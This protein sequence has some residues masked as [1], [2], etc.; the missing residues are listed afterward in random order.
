ME[1]WPRPSPPPPTEG[2]ITDAAFPPYPRRALPPEQLPGLT[3]LGLG[4]EGAPVPL[5][6]LLS[7]ALPGLVTE[8]HHVPDPLPRGVEVVALGPGER[9]FALLGGG[10]LGD[11]P[12]GTAVR[13]PDGR[14]EALLRAHHPTLRVAD[15]NAGAGH[16]VVALWRDPGAAAAGEL[17][18]RDSWLPRAGEGIPVLLHR[19]G[20]PGVPPGDRATHAVLQ[21]ERSLA[22]AFPGAVL[23]VR[24]Q[25]FGIGLRLRALLL[26][27]DGIRAVRGETQGPLDRAREVAVELAAL[28]EA[29]GARLVVSPAPR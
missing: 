20:A 17:L 18:E 11:L 29:R 13:V 26:S 19:T 12:P 4:E 7:G 3:G 23:C 25:A 27:P 5:E 9:R 2:V 24:G 28:L 8:A 10:A 15:G 14:C 6:A 16:A 22:R 21:A 1:T